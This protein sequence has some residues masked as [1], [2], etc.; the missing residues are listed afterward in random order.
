MTIAYAF[1]AGFLTALLLAAA[2]LYGLYVHSRQNRTNATK[3]KGYLDLIPGLSEEQRETVQEIR[4]TFL[5]KVDG[6]RQNLRR[7]RAELARLLFSEPT[8][9]NGIYE[10]ARQVLEHQSELEREVIEHILE[11]KELLTPS[12]K[13]KFYEI[14]IEQFSSG[15]L[16][17][18]D[19]KGRH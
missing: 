8:D 14:I 12:Q 6:I 3:M 13:K 9:R 2:V 1:F 19:V 16:G 17:V 10:V 7:E 5:P 18:H 11:E 4:R 15:G